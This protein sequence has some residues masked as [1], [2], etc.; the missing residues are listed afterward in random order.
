MSTPLPALRFSPVFRQYLW[1]GRR[2][3]DVLGKPIGAGPT[4]AESWEVVDHGEDQSRV[5]GGPFDGQTLTTLVCDRGQDLIGPDWMRSIQSQA[6]PA[7]LR[8]RF[9][10]LIKWLDAHQNLSVQVHPN[11]QQ[12]ALLNPPDFGKTE[13]WYIADALPGSRVYAGLKSGVDRAAF[14]NALAKN[15]V[16][17][18]LHSF[19]PAI[20]DTLFVPAGTVHALGAGLLVAE[21]QQ[22]SNTTFRIFDWD[23]VGSDGR[24]RDL[25]LQ[26]AVEVSEYRAGPIQPIAADAAVPEQV[27][28]H[29]PYFEIER[30]HLTQ[31]REC[32]GNQCQILIGISG[33]IQFR[34]SQPESTS[35]ITKGQTV[36]VPFQMERFE[37]EPAEEAMLLVAKLP[38]HH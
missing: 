33:E 12:A 37:L 24:P 7:H 21:V 8:G 22:A 6:T 18:V 34:G 28:V 26:Q 9:P 13:A 31:S 32:P 4:Y 30:W 14:E 38:N 23:R 17:D 36:L 35:N 29:C 11:D 27:L 10:L 2:L 5:E 1:G 15:R 19:E 20:G 3:G 25:H 16:L